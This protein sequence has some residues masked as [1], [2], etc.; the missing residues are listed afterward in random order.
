MALVVVL[1][2]EFVALV[3]ITVF[4][5]FELL[6][7]APES[8][9][10]A[11]ALTVVVA[12]AALWLGAIVVGAWR[13]GSWTR[14]AS[15]VVQVLLVSVALGSFQGFLPRPDIGWIL[16]LPAIAVFVLLFRSPVRAHLRPPLG[17]DEA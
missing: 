12:L 13:G 1:A 6:V 11:I 3:G 9:A 7:A 10:S 17:D 4:L 15:I 2:L 5:V 16:L 14:G 8:Y